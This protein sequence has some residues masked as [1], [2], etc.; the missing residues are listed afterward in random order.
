MNED[1][2]KEM[3]IMKKLSHPRLIKLIGVCSLEMPY[4]LLTEFMTEGCLLDFIRKS[5]PAAVDHIQQLQFVIQVINITLFN[6]YS[7]SNKISCACLNIY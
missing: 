4:Y 5:E 3:Q 1:F 6:N 7:Y 2:I